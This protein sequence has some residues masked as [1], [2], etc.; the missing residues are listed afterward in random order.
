MPKTTSST[1]HFQITKALRAR[2]SGMKPGHQLPT[3]REL[4]DEMQV[5]QGTIVKTL[6]TL[7]GEGVVERPAGKMRLVVAERHDRHLHRVAIVRPDWPS[8]DFDAVVRS[9]VQAGKRRGWGFDLKTYTSLQNV[10]LNRLT[11]TTDAAVLLPNSEPF[12]DHLRDALRRPTKPAV[13]AYEP[14]RGLGVPTVNVD[15]RWCGK[16]AVEYLAEL[17]HRQILAVMSEPPSAMILDRIAG[18]REAMRQSRLTDDLDALFVN[19]GTQPGQQSIE[20]AYAYFAAWLQRSRQAFTAILC[21]C[22]AA[23]AIMRV[24]RE[25]GL[26]VPEDVSIIA[27]AGEGSVASFL[28]PP[29]TALETDMVRY[30]EAV[31]ECLDRAFSGDH[32]ASEIHI[33][34]ELKI[35]QSTAP[36][37]SDPLPRPA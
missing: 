9:V 36:A 4:A 1:K 14:I 10:D 12:P 32:T 37:R 22:W 13:V 7:R 11:D 20:V 31:I 29:L 18:W 24:L 2:F 5:A 28:N 17:G 16:L 21:D 26:R 3:V 19:C 27:F 33:P 8:T 34:V 6:S 15:D 30:G 23:L 35:R 25:N